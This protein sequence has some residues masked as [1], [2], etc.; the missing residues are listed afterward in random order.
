MPSAP[1]QTCFVWYTHDLSHGESMARRAR[2]P[3]AQ[4][5][6]HGFLSIR[7]KKVR[8][9]FAVLFAGESEDVFH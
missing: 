4:K 3:T 8:V 7:R 2:A 6:R 5:N 1:F 9:K